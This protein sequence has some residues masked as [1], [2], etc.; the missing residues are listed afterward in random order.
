MQREAR[1]ATTL[2]SAH[3]WMRHQSLIF[4]SA[5]LPSVLLPPHSTLS[6]ITADHD[7]QISLT[8]ASREVTPPQKR[9]SRGIFWDLEGLGESHWDAVGVEEGHGGPDL[10]PALL[11]HQLG[12]RTK[13]LSWRSGTG[14]FNGKPFEKLSM[15]C[16]FFALYLIYV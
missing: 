1:I 5:F 14:F 11:R 2:D 7:A 4:F 16:Q 13:L 15:C 8:C 6:H 3:P 12:R 10:V 9:G